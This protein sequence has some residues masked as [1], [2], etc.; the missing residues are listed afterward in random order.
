MSQRDVPKNTDAKEESRRR[1]IAVRLLSLKM[2]LNYVDGVYQY[3]GYNRKNI[4]TE[5]KN[6]EAEKESIEQGQLLLS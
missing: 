6:L 3:T 5:I 4:L 1:E 2:A